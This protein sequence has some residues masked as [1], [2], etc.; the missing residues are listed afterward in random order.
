[1]HERQIE[2]NGPNRAAGHGAIVFAVRSTSKG[3]GM[4]ET[5]GSAHGSGLPRSVGAEGDSNGRVSP[6]P[7]P[8]V[9]SLSH[10]STALGSGTESGLW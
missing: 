10:G 6:R 7:G 8:A 3:K 2:V 9:C 1:M 4:R 5:R